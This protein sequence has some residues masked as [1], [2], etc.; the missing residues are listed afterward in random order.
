MKSLLRFAVG[1]ALAAVLGLAACDDKA[2]QWEVEIEG[3]TSEP[4]VIAERLQL[5]QQARGA[6]SVPE[7]G[8]TILFGDL[9]VHTAYSQ[10]GFLFSLPLLGGEGAH[11]PNDACDFARHCA[12][13]DFYALTDHSEALAPE[14]WEAS[15]RSVR[16]CNARAGSP[17]DPDLVAF[18]GFEWTHAGLTPEEHFGHRCVV[19]PGTADSELPARPIAAKD[20]AQGGRG[21]ARLARSVRWIAPTDWPVHRR[22]AEHQERMADRAICPA[23]LPS[24]AIED[25]QCLELAP[26]PADLHRKLDEWDLPALTIPHGMTWGVY[27]PATAS[28]DKHLEPEHYDPTRMPLIEIMSGHG[29]SEEFRNW[30][31]AG[32]DAEGERYCPAPTADFLPCCWQAGEIMRKRCGDLPADECERRVEQARLYAAQ[33]NVRPNR[34]FPDA[35]PEEWLDCNQC[36]D[37]FKPSFSYRPRESVQYAMSLALPNRAGATRFRFGFIGSS[38][39]HSGRPGNSYK[40]TD[41]VLVSDVRNP[42]GFPYEAAASLVGGSPMEDPRLPQPVPSGP[43]GVQGNDGRVSSFLYPSGLAA[44]HAAGRDRSSIWQAILRREVYGTSGPR[45]LLWFDIL[46][47]IGGNG[48]PARAPMGSEHVLDVNP[49]F[50]V[51]AVGS[52]EPRPGCSDASRR[53]LSPDRLTYL[54]H[55]E[56]Y[57]PSDVRRPI[58][59]IEVVRIRPRRS[60]ADEPAELIDD[61]WRRFEC[62]P[63]PAGCRIEFEDP[64]FAESG[65]DALYYVR[66]LEAPSSGLNGNPLEPQRDAAGNVVAVRLCGTDEIAK[67]GCPAP[68]QERAW[69]S[70]IFVDH[71]G[72][73]APPALERKQP[74]KLANAHR[75]RLLPGLASR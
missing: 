25:T 62:Q 69:S 22:F 33:A 74:P 65:R 18:M 10:D 29:N 32:I 63:D 70:P 43:I 64:D 34:V 23:D 28:F 20:T 21:L 56:C 24:P 17:S 61:P 51:R 57:F 58:A 45:I 16:E 26:T 1:G 13:L 48:G 50:E 41:P 7:D 75:S 14:H 67:G 53:A 38:D 68:T 6:L 71:G 40:Q 72:S 73:A 19:F 39:G 4:G 12:G 52:F 5:Q 66:A 49:R 37:C 47:G 60:A 30:R 46:N 54:C 11:P 3:P 42:P 55:D 31:E 8:N 35:A 9:H 59:A 27:T 44:V 36:R 15:K 2:A